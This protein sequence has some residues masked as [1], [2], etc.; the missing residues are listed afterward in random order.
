LQKIK[1]VVP[2]AARDPS[3]VRRQI[4]VV[5]QASSIDVKLTAAENLQH[6]GAAR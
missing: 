3:G 1:N 6:V 4:G 2:G 5:F